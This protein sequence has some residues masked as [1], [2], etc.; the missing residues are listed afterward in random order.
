MTPER[1]AHARPRPRPV[2]VGRVISAGP[3]VVSQVAVLADVGRGGVRVRT[4]R[5]VPA[6]SLVLLDL[7]GVELLA[8]WVVYARRDADGVWVAG[9]RLVEPL[10]PG[11]VHRLLG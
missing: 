7:P 1:R 5:R 6:R 11:Q 10:S 4:P 2:A 3:G 8:G 9:C